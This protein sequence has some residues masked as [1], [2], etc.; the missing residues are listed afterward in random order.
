MVVEGVSG[1]K[2]VFSTPLV[3]MVGRRG[4]DES[5]DELDEAEGESFGDGGEVRS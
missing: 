3:V 2:A 5:A 4:G 1:V